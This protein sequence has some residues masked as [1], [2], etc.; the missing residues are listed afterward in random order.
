MLLAAT[1]RCPVSAEMKPVLTVSFAGCDKLGANIG[2]ILGPE[3]DTA[4]ALQAAAQAMGLNTKQPWGDRGVD[5]RPEKF[6]AYGFVPVTDAGKLLQWVTSLAARPDMAGKGINQVEVAKA[7]KDQYEI[8]ANGQTVLYA[9]QKGDWLFVAR[10]SEDLAD[11]PDDPAKLLGD[12]PKAYNLVV[13]ASVANIPAQYRE[14]ALAMIRA[15]VE[16]GSGATGTH[17]HKHSIEIRLGSGGPVPPEAI[18]QLKAI[19]NESEQVTLGWNVDP[20]ARKATVDLDISAR[21]GT[22]LADWLARMSPGKTHFAGFLLPDAALVASM[23]RTLSDADVA[24]AKSELARS[25]QSTLRALGMVAAMNG[26]DSD[27]MKWL[28]QMAGEVFDVLDATAAAKKSD[29][30]MSLLVGPN[31]ATFIGGS[32]VANGAKLGDVIEQ[33]AEKSDTPNLTSESMSEPMRRFD[34]TRFCCPSLR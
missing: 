11:L 12:L 5:G 3:A 31:A 32:G 16:A 7:P 29:W 6:T 2:E 15:G 10:K 13:C 34:C 22:Q 26:E 20:V 25:R 14:R 17:F 8:S 19:V 24:N 1:S 21:K 30:G 23:T 18:E 9:Q 4:A 27:E 33:V 28:G